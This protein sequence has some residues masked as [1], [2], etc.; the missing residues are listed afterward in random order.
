MVENSL[1]DELGIS[2]PTKVVEGH[3]EENGL[4]LIKLA[5]AML[6]ELIATP[7]HQ[8]RLPLGIVSSALRSRGRHS[9]TDNAGSSPDTGGK[10]PDLAQAQRSLLELLEQLAKL[11]LDESTLQDPAFEQLLE[12]IKQA[13]SGFQSR[14]VLRT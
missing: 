2:V 4:E 10:S 13:V 12:R 1:N 14:P 3:D 8:S 5:T 7:R 9:A 6:K 11:G